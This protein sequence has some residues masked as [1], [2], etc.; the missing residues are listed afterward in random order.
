[1]CLYQSYP[2]PIAAVLKE[3]FTNLEVRFVH[4]WDHKDEY[5][6]DDWVNLLSDLLCEI[7]YVHEF[8]WIEFP[9]L[10]Y[11]TDKLNEYATQIQTT[12]KI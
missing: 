4:Q 5:G 1:M 9:A 6:L 10:E 7:C 12:Y 3:H 8:S 2:R 11:Y